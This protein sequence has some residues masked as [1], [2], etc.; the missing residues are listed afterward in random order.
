MR[1][2]LN[3][4]L[5]AIAVR[6]PRHERLYARFGRPGGLEWAQM[7]R[8]RGDF[9]AMGDHCYI[10]PSAQ[11]TDRAYIRL[12][13]NVRITA[14]CMMGHEGTVNMINRALGLRLD[15]VGKIDI[16]DNVFIGYG[17]I[18]LPGVT[19]GPNAIVSAGSVVR[20]DVAEGDVVA[21][22]PAKRV[23]RFEMTVEIAKARNLNYPWRHLI[24]KRNSE[25]DPQL[26]P[27]LVRQ[28]VLHFYGAP[29][30]PEKRDERSDR[31]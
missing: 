19:I 11:I 17:V 22:V 9:Y 7:L 23:G 13:N 2:W 31:A 24:E 10:E 25:F 29:S 1:N 15:G 8:E 4:L 16:R 14:C 21:G 5:R 20:A 28:R 18:I 6:Y 3:K 26:E 30:M 12:G 27:E